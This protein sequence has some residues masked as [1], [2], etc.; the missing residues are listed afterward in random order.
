M[1]RA[2]QE[3]ARVLENRTIGP[4]LHWLALA[5]PRL[6]AQSPPLPGQFLHM[7]PDEERS[8]P[9]L[10]RP[11][12][13]LDFDAGDGRVEVYLQVFGEGS[14]ILAARGPGDPLEIIGSAGR[15]FR[16]TPPERALYL[17]AGGVGLAPLYFLARRIAARAQAARPRRVE[18]LLGARHA[19][20]LPGGGLLERL[21]QPPRIATD[22]GSRGA[23]GTVVALLEQLLEREEGPVEVAGCG[24]SPMLAALE[25]FL[26]RRRL[27]GQVSLEQV[28]GCAMG[29]CQGCVV[30]ARLAD[31]GTG[32]GE[33]Y[34]RVC[35][36]GPVFEAGEVD[37]DALAGR[38]LFRHAG[39]A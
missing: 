27:P 39:G 35:T 28:M 7:L 20:L 16:D 12:S 22:D 32:A 25:R 11:I 13:V 30:P 36:E 19:G 33:G 24:P 3:T 10:C 18:L 37:W 1:K 21:P 29:A 38:G 2:V 14:R 8:D 34:A 9:L 5:A 26:A 23:R 17:V 6:A 4:G 31:R 15:A